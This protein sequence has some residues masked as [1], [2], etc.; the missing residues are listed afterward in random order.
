PSVAITV[1]LVRNLPEDRPWR[2]ADDVVM[3][4]PFLVGWEG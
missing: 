1:S 3:V 4:V 2:D